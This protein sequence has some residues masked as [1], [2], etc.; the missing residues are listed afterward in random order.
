MNT[1]WKLTADDTLSK[2]IWKQ[3]KSN[4]KFN[5]WH[6]AG[7]DIINGTTNILKQVFT[8]QI[9]GKQIDAKV[10]AMEYNYKLGSRMIEYQTTNSMNQKEV[11]L[12]SL[13]TQERI[14]STMERGKTARSKIAQSGRTDRTRIYAALKVARRGYSSGYPFSTFGS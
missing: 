9:A 7:I 13:A 10:K 5:Q 8:R 11:A 12:A 14:A 6:N 3:Q 4:M 2:D 1:N